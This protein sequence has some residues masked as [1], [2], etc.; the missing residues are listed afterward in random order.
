VQTDSLRWF[1]QV[2]DGVTVTEVSDL[3][4]VTQSGVSRALARLESDVGTPLLQRSGRVLRMT[5]AGAAFKRHVDAML[6]ELDDGLAAVNQLLDPDTGT[7]AV[8]FQAS[9]G[10]WLVPEL[11]SSFLTDHRDAQFLL[12]E[13]RDELGPSQVVQGQVDLEISALYQRGPAM[14]WRPFLTERL[15]LAVPAGHPL[16]KLRTVGLH[17]AAREPFVGLPET[18]ALR[19]QS[20]E[21]G[22]A[23]GFEPNVVFECADLAAVRGFVAAGLGVAIVPQPRRTDKASAAKQI[24]F[25]E[26]SD[27][28]AR[29]EIGVIWA[30][31]RRLLPAPE[32]FLG[33]ILSTAVG[34]IA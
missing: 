7:I 5:R 2:A 10:T 24:M 12:A 15:V 21:L 18:L 6:H 17:A 20:D 11:I 9:L 13:V 4:Q 29:R 22:R 26:L 19:R 14:H 27:A 34:G 8:A 16:G 1:Q 33:H 25:V 32:L 3:E 28:M 30:A 23:A 31:D